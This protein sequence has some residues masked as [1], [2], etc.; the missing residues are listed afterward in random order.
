MAPKDGP[1]LEG[2]LEFALSLDKP[3]AIRYPRGAAPG[4]LAGS[5]GPKIEPGKAEICKTG[6]D[7][8]I[9]ALGSMVCPAL[10]AAEMLEKEGVSAAVVN[11]R[12]CQTAGR[13][14]IQ[15]IS[16]V[17]KSCFYR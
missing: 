17:G 8:A 11:A 15:G 16:I 13:R 1:E 2:M 12:F 7:F 10:E 9:I 5:P 4:Q 6:K 14:L 3:S